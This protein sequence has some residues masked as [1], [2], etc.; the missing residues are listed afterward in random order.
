MSEEEEALAALSGGVF[1]NQ[2]PAEIHPY[3]VS[4]MESPSDYPRPVDLSKARRRKAASSGPDRI[5][6]LPPHS[7]EAEQGVLGCILLDP[8]MCLGRAIE[9]LGETGEMFYDLRHQTIYEALVQSFNDRVQIDIIT[10]QQRLKDRSLLEQIGGIAYLNALQDF[11]PSAANLDYYLNYVE[12]KFLLR[13]TV[14][15]CT[16]IVGRVYSYSGDSNELFDEIERDMNRTMERRTRN[17]A[18]PVGDGVADALNT[19]EAYHH[20]R[21]SPGA[22]RTGFADFDNMMMGGCKLGEMIVIAARP[23]MGKT[24]LAMN[25]AEHVAV[26]NRI[27]VGVFSLEMTF[28][29]L[30]LRLICANARVSLRN[31]TDGFLADSDFPRL[32]NAAGRIRRAPL[33]ID[34]TPAISVLQLRSKARR[35]V[36]QYGIRLFVIDY[37]QLMVSLS[38]RARENRQQE[39]AEISAGIKA[40]AK[41]LNLPIIVL[42]QLNRELEKDK[43]RKPRMSDLRESGAVEQDADLIGMLYKPEPEEG[44]SQTVDDGQPFVAEAVNLFIAKQRNG[45]TGDVRFTFIKGIT[46]FESASRMSDEDLPPEAQQGELGT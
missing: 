25:I 35:M 21:G 40:L 46:R 41:E 37:L 17:G 1:N 8:S 7:I 18:R 4:S 30:N 5:D 12:E 13:R 44:Q 45:P 9:K 32:T 23:S 27:P 2:Q 6:R 3:P 24:S 33:Y 20:G 19:I 38:K 43:F 15:V 34:D 11:V 28:A 10:L 29:A 14:Q 31:V 42:A 36:Q 39:I 16:D 22:I 26:N